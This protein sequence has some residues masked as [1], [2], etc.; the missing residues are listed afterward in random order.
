MS[1]LHEEVLRAGEALAVKVTWRLQS[2]G[3]VI[4]GSHLKG[5]EIGSRNA[6]HCLYEE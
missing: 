3:G 1:Y 2:T 4:N 6:S 5:T